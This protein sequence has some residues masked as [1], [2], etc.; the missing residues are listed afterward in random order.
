VRIVVLDTGPL[1]LV[2][3][4]R[5]TEENEGCRQWLRDVLDAGALVVIPEIADY[6]VRRELIRGEKASGL[7]RLD[8]LRNDPSFVFLPLTSAA[9]LRAAEYWAAARQQGTPTADDKALDGDV[10]LAAQ[11]TVFQSEED[12]VVVATSNPSHLRLFVAA[13]LWQNIPS[14]E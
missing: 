12:R 11:V 3:N 6:E 7:R 13:E 10:I 2:T 8:L 4:P 5:A 14:A 9:M 1:G